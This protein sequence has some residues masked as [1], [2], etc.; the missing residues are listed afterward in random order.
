M[1]NLTIP[2]LIGI[3]V[4]VFVVVVVVVGVS[5]FFK[6]SVIDFFK[7]WIGG[8]EDL[9]GGEEVEK[10]K[11]YKIDRVGFKIGDDTVFDKEVLKTGEVEFIVVS[12]DNCEK[13]EYQIFL[14][15]GLLSTWKFWE[16]GFFGIDDE[17]H[18]KLDLDEVNGILNSLSSGTYHIVASCF[19][20]KG[21]TKIIESKNLEIK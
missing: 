8:E 9:P 1:A 16:K 4:G 20:K 13:V 5:I 18:A 6:D 10:T 7:N 11:T 3:I 21:K 15:K 19:D 14:N 2:Q 17:I 12:E